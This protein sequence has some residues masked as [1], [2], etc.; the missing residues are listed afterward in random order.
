VTPEQL[1]HVVRAACRARGQRE[2][3]IVGSQVLVGYSRT[4]TRAPSR[5]ILSVEADMYFPGSPRDTSLLEAHGYGSLFHETHGY[6]IDPVSELTAVLPVDWADRQMRF[7]IDSL[8]DGVAPY[9]AILPSIPDLIISK[10]AAAANDGGVQRDDLA[11]VRDALAIEPVDVE[12]LLS[13]ADKIGDY[14][15]DLYS[16]DG[17]PSLRDRVRDLVHVVIP[18]PAF[19]PAGRPDNF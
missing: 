15:N 13:L 18:D 19:T 12:M 7:P 8:V 3:V 5:A 4:G 11:F 2:V 1:A 10:L 17:H 14:H 6:Y 9:Q 16:S